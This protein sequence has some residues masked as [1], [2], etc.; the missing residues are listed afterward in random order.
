MKEFDNDLD[1]KFKFDFSS[2]EKSNINISKLKT[3]IK[4][5][6]EAVIVFY[7]GE[8]LLEIEKIKEIMDNINVP[9]R[10]QTNGKL[11]NELPPKY[12]NKIEK[13]LISLDGTEE[14]TDFNRSKGTY[15][16]VMQNIKQAIENG[17]KGELIA[18]M[19]V[20][21][22]FPDIYE[23]VT[24]LINNKDFNFTSIHWQLDA[25]FFKFD[26]NEESFQIFT[27]EYNKSISKLIDFWVADMKEN[28]RVLRL[29][30][31]L[32]I[33][34]SIINNEKTI[35]RCGAGHAGYAITTD[36]KVVACPIMNCIENFKAGTLDTNPSQLKKFEVSGRCLNC[37]KEIKNLC[38]G[39]CLY[40][41]Q[42]SL[43]PKEGDDLICST[44]KHLI[45]ELKSNIPKI[46]QLIASK[47]ISKD[48]FNYE[49]YFGPEIIP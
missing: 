24:H 28:K 31:F 36:G 29:Y 5:D 41:N 26:F 34:H 25:G 8:P 35:L 12:L 47:T 43:W 19:T 22:A 13:I 20:S 18:R 23:Q 38:G 11:L 15:K 27:Q 9:F 1:K 17:Y 30:P 21:P 42:A 3:F 39:R 7:G 33:T 44:I 48:D 46:E 2:P 37:N 32:A 10:M 16:K 49:K 6:K 40:W 45:S 4:K 14:R